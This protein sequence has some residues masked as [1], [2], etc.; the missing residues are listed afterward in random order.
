MNTN[1]FT[2]NMINDL[3]GKLIWGSLSSVAFYSIEIGDQRIDDKGNDYGEYS[4]FLECYW[5]IAKNNKVI[6]NV[7]TE[8]RKFKASKV[9]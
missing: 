5:H 8:D 2:N 3:Q 7:W 1:S 9:C 4:L 6:I